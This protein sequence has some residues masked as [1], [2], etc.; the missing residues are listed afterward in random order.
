MIATSA[1]SPR[2]TPPQRQLRV[3]I[4]DDEKDFALTTAELLRGEGH[5]TK[6]CYRGDE[7]IRHVEEYDPDVVILDIRLPGKSGWE[8]AS[9]IRRR[10]GPRRPLLIGVSGEYTKASDQMLSK[11]NGFDY[12]LIKPADPSVLFL[13]LRDATASLAQ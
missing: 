4:C 12:Y 11:I 7:V 6:T 9:E 3:L 8:A 1:D 10:F 5:D 2:P 13:L